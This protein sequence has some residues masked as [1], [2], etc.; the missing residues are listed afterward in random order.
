M[1]LTDLAFN[2][3]V[4]V[5]ERGFMT[6]KFRRLTKIDKVTPKRIYIAGDAYD[7]ESGRCLAQ[8][9]NLSIRVPTEEDIQTNTENQRRRKENKEAIAAREEKQAQD[10]AF[11]NEFNFCG[12]LDETLT[13]IRALIQKD[14]DEAGW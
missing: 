9:S 12:L 2:D 1:K 3:T 4:S 11:L 6:P 13:A 14:K 5:V 7:R 10:A 8:Y